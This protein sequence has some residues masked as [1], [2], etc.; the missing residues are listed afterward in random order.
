MDRTVDHLVKQ[1]KEMATDV[2]DAELKDV[3]TVSA[4]G[5]E[6]VSLSSRSVEQPAPPACARQPVQRQCP[7]V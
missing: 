6:N 2:T 4:G 5:N 3:A 7:A 1:L